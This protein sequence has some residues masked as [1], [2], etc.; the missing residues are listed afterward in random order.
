MCGELDFIYLRLIL[1]IHMNTI[2][3][4]PQERSKFEALP[5]DLRDGWEIVDETLESAYETPEQLALRAE[6]AR[7]DRNPYIKTLI[8]RLQSGASPDSLSL[9]DIPESYFPVIFYAIG[10]S[11]IAMLIALHLGEI[12][13]DEDIQEL[14]GLSHVRHDILEA[15]AAIPA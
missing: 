6:V 11:G 9:A 1:L 3:L 2:H 12:K 14:A 15:N 13:T 4:T 10:A 5:A 7:L 8:E